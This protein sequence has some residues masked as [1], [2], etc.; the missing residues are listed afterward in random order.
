MRDDRDT[1]DPPVEREGKVQTAGG[2]DRLMALSSRKM[3]AIG[4]VVCVVAGAVVGVWLVNTAGTDGSSGRVAGLAS[5]TQPTASQGLVPVAQ[6]TPTFVGSAACIECHAAET[7]LWTGS[8]HDLAMAKPTPETVRGDF[9]NTSFTH[10]GVTTTF[11][12]RDGNYFVKTDNARGEMEE[13][14]VAYTFG[15]EPLQQYL[16]EAEGGRL[17]TLGVTWDTRPQSEGGQRWYHVYPDEPVDSTDELHWTGQYQN[18]NHMCAECHST[19]LQKNYDVAANTYNTTWSEINVA[20]EA[21]HGPASRHVEMASGG[22]FPQQE[23]GAAGK[24]GLVT[25]LTDSDCDGW[26]FEEGKPTAVRSTPRTDHAQIN[27]CAR[28]HSRRSSITGTYE[29]GRDILDTH[30]VST[31]QE[32]LY[33]PDG[34]ILDEVYVYG[35][36]IQSKMYHKG[37][38][39]TDCHE[40]HGLKLKSPG[41]AACFRCHLP[42][43]FDTPSHT[44]HDAGTAASQCVSCHMPTRVYMGVDERL[45]HSIRV[46][47]PDLSVALGTPNAC[48][49]CHT[50]QTAQWAA[51][52]VARWYGEDR[53]MEPHFG[54]AIAAGR[55]HARGASA[56]LVELASDPAQPGIARATALTL[57]RDQPGQVTPD[58]IRAMVRD[59]DPMV[60]TAVATLLEDAPVEVRYQ[61]LTPLLTDEIRSPRIE[62]ARVLAPIEPRLNEPSA[63]AA[64]T[65]ALA[66]YIASEEAN[67]DRAWSHTNLGNLFSQQGFAEK[68]EAA[69]KAAIRLDPAYIQASVN[70]ADLY[71]SLNR[72]PEGE[73]VLREAIA[74][75]DDQA[76][77]R[78]ALGLLLIRTGRLGAAVDE[79]AAA[80]ALDP[81]DTR[82]AYVHA[83]ALES[84]GR[85]DDALAELSRARGLSPDDPEILGALISYARKAGQLDLAID[86]AKALKRVTPDDPSLPQLIYDLER[87]R[88]GG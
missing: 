39:C 34:Q 56:L 81:D 63:R 65:E 8:H 29:H 85:I 2:Y 36:F 58:L 3:L 15:I 12:K 1:D 46:P 80:A 54:T 5:N 31:L 35:S 44:F 21:C 42:N 59:P 88:R 25:K 37:V 43:A 20:C 26:V 24:R 11:T 45:D 22:T 16:L 74:L 64:L 52:A 9:N 84:V 49:K 50:D 72:D 41:N 61:Y 75:H 68:A 51:D 53:R 82:M 48:N 55:A 71:R 73:R 69:Y 67:S 28:C 66:E 13:F 47:R 57:L 17:Q 78:H 87:Q 60:R 30:R 18:W 79:L 4:A 86:A 7:A 14:K 40:P 27:A 76:Q 83:V 33:E 32:L 77:L 70:L 62:A 6:T 19:D 23:L 10:F 38:T